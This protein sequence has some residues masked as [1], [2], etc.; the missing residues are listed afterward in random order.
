MNLDRLRRIADRGP[1]PY[2]V[3][4]DLRDHLTGLDGR[5]SWIVTV[6]LDGHVEASLARTDRPPTDREAANFF[7]MWDATPEAEAQ[8]GPARTFIRHWI[9]RRAPRPN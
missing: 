7:R 2:P 5:M 6:D 3:P 9:V 4:P 1:K 8:T